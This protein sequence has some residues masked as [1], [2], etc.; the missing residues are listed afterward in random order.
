M[1]TSFLVI[2]TFDVPPLFRRTGRYYQQK[3]KLILVEG[4]FIITKLGLNRVSTSIFTIDKVPG[5][6][7]LVILFWGTEI[8]YKDYYEYKSSKGRNATYYLLD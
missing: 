1:L 3:Q 5:Q 4:S 6:C 7:L 8:S 2:N